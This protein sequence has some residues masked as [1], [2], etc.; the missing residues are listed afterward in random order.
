MACASVFWDLWFDLLSP[1]LVG[2]MP[3]HLQ[4]PKSL[5]SILPQYPQTNTMPRRYPRP[6]QRTQSIQ[7]FHQILCLLFVGSNQI[8]LGRS[9]QSSAFVSPACCPFTVTPTEPFIQF[10]STA[11]YCFHTVEIQHCY[12]CTQGRSSSDLFWLQA[13]LHY[14]YSCQTYGKINR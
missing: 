7:F 1:C 13:R 11:I 3:A 4:F 2:I 8:H 12:P 9:W 5:T 14:S 10:V 6:G